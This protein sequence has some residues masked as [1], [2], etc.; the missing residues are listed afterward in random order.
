MDYSGVSPDQAKRLNLLKL[1]INEANIPAST[2][3]E[4]LNIA[5][6]NIRDFGKKS[7]TD[8]A[9]LFIAE[10]L[11]QF[12]IIAITELR[13]DLSDLK[14]V[15]NRLGPY[16]KFVLSDWQDDWG[17]NWERTAFIY[18]NRMVTFTGLAAEAQPN[19]KKI[20]AEYISEQS[21]WRS[22]YLASFRAGSFDFILMATHIRWGKTEAQRKRE[23]ASFGE[24]INSR[25]AD[26][27]DKVFDK[28]LILMGDFNIPKIG[29]A[30]YEALCQPS[31][32][33]MPDALANIK[34]TVASNRVRRYDQILHLAT[35]DIYVSRHGGVIDFA[36]DALMEA[37][38]PAID[39]NKLTYQLSDHFPLWMQVYTD[40]D[41]AQ[42][43]SII[44]GEE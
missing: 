3:D 32:L 38:L 41:R 37:L 25:W 21:W 12:D 11:Y 5:T 31:G 29:D 26:D 9:I 24:W 33:V 40:N 27:K 44:I 2:L 4:S 23:L 19:R 15:L 16:W 34:D 28:D 17:G 30:L 39:N 10:I 18:D 43:D 8:D 20:G 14:R 42:L 22:P 7:R 36:T 6:W 13:D 1:R 35:A